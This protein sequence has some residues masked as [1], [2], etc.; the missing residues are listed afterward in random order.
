MPGHGSSRINPLGRYINAGSKVPAPAIKRG[1]RDQSTSPSNLL[2]VSPQGNQQ[3]LRPRL[4]SPAGRR[5]PWQRDRPAGLARG[6][7][8]AGDLCRPSMPDVW[9]TSMLGLWSSSTEGIWTRARSSSLTLLARTASLALSSRKDDRLSGFISWQP[10]GDE[11]GPTHAERAEAFAKCQVVFLASMRILSHLSPPTIFIPCCTRTP[12]RSID[13]TLPLLCGPSALRALTLAPL[14]RKALLG[15][16]M[17]KDSGLLRAMRGGSYLWHYDTDS[18]VA[19]LT[20]EHLALLNS[21]TSRLCPFPCPYPRHCF[22]QPPAAGPSVLRKSNC[23]VV[24]VSA[25]A[26]SQPTSAKIHRHRQLIAQGL[27]KLE[28]VVSVTSSGSPL[29]AIAPALEPGSKKTWPSLTLTTSDGSS[30]EVP[31]PS[32]R[33]GEIFHRA[34]VSGTTTRKV[35]FLV[36]YLPY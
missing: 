15:Y 22:A 23:R 19:I 25:A 35:D 29:A 31:L 16:Q 7:L 5:R 6:L 14:R 17:H 21:D 24:P 36:G 20:S 13:R 28:M 4:A 27:V 11:E 33:S 3:T 9:S 8:G 32:G 12:H 26:P 10:A 1:S 30:L 34:V 2:F 18:H